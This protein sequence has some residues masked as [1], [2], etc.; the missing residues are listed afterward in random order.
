MQLGRDDLFAGSGGSLFIDPDHAYSAIRQAE[1]IFRGIRG[2]ALVCDPYVDSRTLDY[3]AEFESAQSIRLL[4]VNIYK[5]NRFKRD[6][7]AFTRS[8]E[9]P[10]SRST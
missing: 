1:E 5:E 9:R 7:K 2:L 6:L 4:T 10:T 3:L 8:S